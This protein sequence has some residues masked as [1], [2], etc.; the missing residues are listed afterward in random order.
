VACDSGGM[1]INNDSRNSLLRRAALAG[2]LLLASGGLFAAI[3]TA[4]PAK[5]G[6][7][8]KRDEGVVNRGMIESASF[9]GVVK[10]VA[11]SI[12]KVTVQIRPRNAS[13]ESGDEGSPFPGFSDRDLRQFFGNRVPVVPETPESGLGSGVII[14]TDGYIVT[15]NHVVDGAKQVTVT[16]TDGREFS[17]RVVGRDPQ[18]DV[19]VIKVSAKDLPAITF[20]P[21]RN[22]EVGDRVLAIGNPFGIGET[23]TTGIVSATGRRAGIGLKYED[24]IQTD[25]A[26]NPG[27]SGGALVDVEGRLV[28]INTAILS[29]SGGFQGVGLAVPSDLVGNVAETLVSSGKVVRG[30]IGVGIQDLTPGLADS[31]GLKTQGGALVSDV[32][33]D[34]PAA[35]AGIKSGDVVTSVDGQP[36]TSASRLSLAVGET[37]PGT[38]VTLDIL[39]DG[40]ARKVSVTSVTRPSGDR[41]GGDEPAA[42]DDQGVL[43]GVAVGDID[44]NARHQLDFPERL[45]GALITGVDPGSASARAGLREGDVILEINRQPVSSAKSAVDLSASAA[46]KRTLLK[47]WSHGNT[48][49]VVV[50]ESGSAPVDSA[51]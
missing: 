33:P 32:Q 48:V 4:V 12:V 51:P 20:A 10:R 45:S 35:K 50:D 24:F 49:Y 31:F 23:V 38:R 47:L 22:V 16:L 15:N 34:S 14:S 41:R 44:S 37:P 36:V 29:R 8:L 30:Y 5:H 1:P 7:N 9:A 19:A 6:I 2:A 39:R 18:T 3:D 25:A 43:N 17:A 28:G 11:P 40:E 26:I 27:N 42:T 21:S 13:M 46:S